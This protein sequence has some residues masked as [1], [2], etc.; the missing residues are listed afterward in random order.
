MHPFVRSDTISVTG[1]KTGFESS[2]FWNTIPHACVWNDFLCLIFWI[3]VHVCCHFPVWLKKCIL[4]SFVAL[5][6]VFTLPGPLPAFCQIS[7]FNIHSLQLNFNPNTLNLAPTYTYRDK[8]VE[9]CFILKS[10]AYSVDFLM[11]VGIVIVFSSLHLQSYLHV[12]SN[13]SSV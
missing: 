11:I 9:L 12:W 2:V 3:P 8:K 13:Q 5:F 7:P 10:Q 1:C 6:T 4:L